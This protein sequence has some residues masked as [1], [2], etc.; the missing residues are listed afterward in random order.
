MRL[1]FAALALLAGCSTSRP[2]VASSEE[3]PEDQWSRGVWLYGQHCASCHGESAE[4]SEDA[5]ALAG[6]GALPV[7]AGE[8]STRARTFDT[9]LDVFSYA[10]ENM[11]L[12]EPGSLKDDQYWAVLA[13]S[14]KAGGREVEGELDAQKAA[15]LKLQR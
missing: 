11:P 10:R 14:L 1:L 4:G 7:R 15:S 3:L 13:Y 8:G 6:K 12:L 9:A 5:P 2:E